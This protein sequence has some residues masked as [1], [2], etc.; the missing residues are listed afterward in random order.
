MTYGYW[1]SACCTVESGGNCAV[2]C[3][4]GDEFANTYICAFYDNAVFWRVQLAMCLH[5]VW[6]LPGNEVLQMQNRKQQQQQ[7]QQRQE[8]EMRDE[9]W[10]APLRE[11]KFGVRGG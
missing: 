4:E 8:V 1:C 10:K 5:A 6:C 9:Q 3:C 11:M 2:L 7:Q